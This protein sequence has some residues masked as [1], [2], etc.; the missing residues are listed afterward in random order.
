MTKTAAWSQNQQELHVCTL[1][2][3][4]RDVVDDAET[5]FQSIWTHLQFRWTHLQCEEIRAKNPA[6][7]ADGAIE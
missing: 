7:I 2:L 4:G 3:G 6:S 5:S 1:K